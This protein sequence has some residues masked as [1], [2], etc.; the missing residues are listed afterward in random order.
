MLMTIHGILTLLLIV[1]FVALCLWAYSP[2]RE[3]TF[4]DNANIPFIHNEISS[5]VGEHNH[6]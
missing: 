5:R 3:K 2:S 6:D 4:S 1:A